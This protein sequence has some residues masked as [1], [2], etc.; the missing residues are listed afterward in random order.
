VFKEF[1]KKLDI[2][3]SMS[4]AYHPQTDGQTERI[5]QTLEQYLHIFCSS[6]QDDWV[7]LLASAEFAYN[8]AASKATQQSPFFLEYGYHLQMTPI[9]MQEFMVPSVEDIH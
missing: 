3:G 7:K 9:D 5:N 1:L 6:H 8:N 2:K 4:S